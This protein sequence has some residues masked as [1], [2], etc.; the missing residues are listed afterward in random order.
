MSLMA[1]RPAR[2]I[3]IIK[4]VPFPLFAAFATW[5][6]PPSLYFGAACCIK[7]RSC[8]S[9]LENVFRPYRAW[10]FWGREPRA[11]LSRMAGSFALD[12]YLSGLQPF[13]SA[14][15]S[16]YPRQKISVALRVLSWPSLGVAELHPPKF[17]ALRG[18]RLRY[19]T[20]RRGKSLWF[21]RSFA[22]KNLCL[23]LHRGLRQ[24][25]SVF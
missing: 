9:Q 10:N 20:T 23:F 12:Y 18:F 3:R 17:R 24:M 6:L 22:A 1:D 19:V 4:S 21:L 8:C 7:T 14:S 13:Q 11:A 2:Q 25:E 16:V 15:I 5:R